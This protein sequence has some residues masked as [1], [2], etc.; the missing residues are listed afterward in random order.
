MFQV[1]DDDKDWVVDTSN[2]LG[3]ELLHPATRVEDEVGG[4]TV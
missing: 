3:R 2:G 1:M 4:T